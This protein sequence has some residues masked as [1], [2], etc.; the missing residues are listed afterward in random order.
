AALRPT[1]RFVPVKTE[2]QQAR[3]M[4]FRTRQMFVGQR[5]QMINALRG[6]LAEHGLVAARGPAHLKRLADAIAEEDIALPDD[7]RELGRLY[8]EQIDGLTA[9]MAELDGKMK[10][11]TKE[12][13][14]ARRAQIMPGVDPVLALAIETFA[15]DLATFRRGRDFAAWPGLVPKQH[16][17]GGKPRLGQTSKMG[18]RDIR[19]LLVSGAMAVLQALERF[20]TPNNGWLK[21]LQPRKPRMVVAIALANKMARPLWAML[22][23]QQD[24]RSPVAAMA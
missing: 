8:L 12:A 24:Y 14:L 7:V 6:H 16:S 1:M 5:T 4:L 13:D 23:K 9:R 2:D 21:C 3:A 20:D 18:Q 19:R 11:T 22:T 10:R 17:T 15:P